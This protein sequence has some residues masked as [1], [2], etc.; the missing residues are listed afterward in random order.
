MG[1][2][3]LADAD[4]SGMGENTLHHPGFYGGLE[5]ELSEYKDYL[6]FDKEYPITKESVVMDMPVCIKAMVKRSMLYPQMN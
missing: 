6:D 2:I 1:G 4:T 3:I 5:N